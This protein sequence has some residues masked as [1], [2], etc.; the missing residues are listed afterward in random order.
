MIRKI[1]IH[2]LAV[3]ILPFYPF[4][5]KSFARSGMDEKIRI[6]EEVLV[7]ISN[8]KGKTFLK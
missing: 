3:L 6:Q 5:K 8:S 2:I 4:L 7:V 1:F